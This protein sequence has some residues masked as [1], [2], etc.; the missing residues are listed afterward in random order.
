[1]SMNVYYLYDDGAHCRLNAAGLDYT[2]AYIPALAAYMGV[3]I[4]PVSHSELNTL[5]ND[6]VLIVGAQKIDE[7]PACRTILLGSTLRGE[8]KPAERVRRVFAHCLIGGERQPLFVPVKRPETEGEIIAYAALDNGEKVPAIVKGES[9]LEFCFDLAA[10]VW[11]SED[12]FVPEELPGYF[13]IGRTPDTRP[14][15]GLGHDA[16]NDTLVDVLENTLREFGVPTLYRLIPTADGEAPD[17]VMHFSGDDDCASREFNLSAAKTMFDLGLPYHINAMPNNERNGFVF[18]KE[19]VAMLRDLGCELALHTNFL[20]ISHTL[21]SVKQQAE[22]FV[23]CLGIQ[24]KTNV[25][26][27][28]VQGGST[29]ERLRWFEA[30]GI[31]GENGKCGLYNPENINAFDLFG[32]TFGTAFPRFGL[33]DAEHSNAPISTMEIPLNY[34]EPRIYNE[35]DSTDKVIKYVD[36]MVYYGRIGQ[37]FFHPHYLREGSPEREGALRAINTLL[38]RAKERGYK[39]NYSTTNTIADFWMARSKAT[40]RRDGNSVLVKCDTPLLLRLPRDLASDVPMLDGKVVDVQKKTV[41]AETAILVYIP[42]GEHIV[43]L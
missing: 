2:P 16:Y 42:S 14:L 13:Y 6:D 3:S 41:G 1:M 22:L 31:I 32:H 40:V 43:T 39:I 33:D 27:C 20:G 26:H 28:L 25:N 29:A 24:P 4:T 11:F 34:Y 30:C 36:D 8:H 12:G 35:G 15:D 17:A 5:V 19:V 37:F 18:E 7:L 21:E 38:T 23:S 10:T 9:T